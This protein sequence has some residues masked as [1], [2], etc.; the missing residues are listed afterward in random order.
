MV[1]EYLEAVDATHAEFGELYDELTLWS[2]PFG[3]ML[4]AR[5]PVKSELTILDIGAGTGFTTVELAQRCGSKTQVIA[6]DPWES[7]MKRLRA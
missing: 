7:G 6:V 2:A 1:V 4:L 5:V 3:L